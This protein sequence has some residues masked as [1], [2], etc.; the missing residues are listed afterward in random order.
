MIVITMALVPVTPAALVW[1]LATLA[2]LPSLAVF[3]RDYLAVT[4]RIGGPNAN[5]PVDTNE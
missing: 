4:G 1:P 5:H 2:M 3:L